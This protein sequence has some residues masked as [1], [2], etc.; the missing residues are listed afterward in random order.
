MCWSWQQPRGR[1]I[2]QKQSDDSSLPNVPCKNVWP[3]TQPERNVVDDLH[4][5][6]GGRVESF[7]LGSSVHENESGDSEGFAGLG[8][9]LHPSSLLALL[10][11]LELLLGHEASAF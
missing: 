1:D 5:R 10:P 7:A 9:S 4:H 11:V 3:S 8:N 2:F 6:L